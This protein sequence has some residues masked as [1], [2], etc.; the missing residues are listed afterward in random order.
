MRKSLG[1]RPGER[2]AI[3]VGRLVDTKRVCDLVE[4]TIRV[5]EKDRRLRLVIV[6][7]GPERPALERQVAGANLQ[8]DVQFL[9]TRHDVVSLLRSADMFVFPSEMEGLSNAVIEASLA[10]LPIVGCD[11]GGV[12]DVVTSGRECQLVPTRDP[13]AMAAAMCEYLANE[14]MATAHGSA[15]RQRAEGSYAIE[16]TLER[17]YSLYDQV[18]GATS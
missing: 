8:D 12:H 10:G 18:L 7:D 16:N 15:A 1:I 17:L 2:V 9:G 13:Q 14:Q 5:R 11:I 3:F 4:A 6:G